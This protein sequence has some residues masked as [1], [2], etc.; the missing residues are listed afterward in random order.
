MASAMG[1]AAWV[2]LRRTHDDVVRECLR[3][4][5]GRE[6]SHTGDGFLVLFDGPA[7]AVTCAARIVEQ[8]R[9]LGIEI[10]VGVHTGEVELIGDQIGGVAVHLASRILD[11]AGSGTI[12]ASSTVKDLVLGSGIGFM[13]RGPSQLKGVPDTWNLFQVTNV[14]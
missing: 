3:N 2:A 8:V 12:L 14:P 5:R 10:R 4:Y 13:D 11:E 9:D 1:D 6:I 7:R